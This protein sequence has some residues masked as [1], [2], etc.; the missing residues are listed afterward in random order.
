MTA[1][2]SERPRL[3][4]V[5]D[6]DL[7]RAVSTELAEAL[8]WQVHPASSAEEAL[9]RWSTSSTGFDAVMTDLDLSGVDGLELIDRLRAL[10]PNLPALV[11]SGRADDQRVAARLRRGDIEYLTKPVAAAQLERS[12]ARLRRPAPIAAP[13][14]PAA[15]GP[16]VPAASGPVASAPRSQWPLLAGGAG[17]AIATALVVALAVPRPPELPALSTSSITRGHEV[18]A[19]GPRG[20]LSTAPTELSW[21][22]VSAAALYQVVVESATEIQLWSTTSEQTSIVV[23]PEVRARLDSRVTYFWQVAA[24]DAG[25]S[26]VA[27]SPR[28]RFVIVGESGR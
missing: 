3:L 2:R 20:E 6:R 23:P 11:L 12:L 19:L 15:T 7:V 17:L 24:I 4:L 22:P 26:V 14:L 25:G 21:Q 18:L 28:V 27:W 10:R 13:A 1:P 5:E 16:S 9:A 8:G